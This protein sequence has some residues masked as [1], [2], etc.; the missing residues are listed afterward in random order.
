[1]SK[2]CTLSVLIIT[3]FFVSHLSACKQ[4]F[5]DSENPNARSPIDHYENDYY[6]VYSDNDSGYGMPYDYYAP[7]DNTSH[8]RPKEQP[9]SS[10]RKPVENNAEYTPPASND[11]Y[12]DYDQEY[13]PII[14]SK[15]RD[16]EAKGIYAPFS[17][18][19]VVPHSD[20][21]YDPNEE[22]TKGWNTQDNDFIYPLE[23]HY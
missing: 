8:Y 23:Y 18:D 5:D 6:P 3:L 13:Y 15:Q 21:Y 2:N 1:M 11:Y 4:K 10:S 7:S 12:Y 22:N 9:P 17:T 16:N 14:S 20:P 19:N